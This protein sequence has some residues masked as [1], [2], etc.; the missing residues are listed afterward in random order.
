VLSKQF[1]ANII[2]ALDAT[3]LRPDSGAYSSYVPYDTEKNLKNTFP[4]CS[5]HDKRGPKKGQKKRNIFQRD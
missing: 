1:Q 3:T 5:K 2:K 4:L